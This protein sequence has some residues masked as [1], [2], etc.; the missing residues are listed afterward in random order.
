MVIVLCSH[1]EFDCHG[2]ENR[3]RRWFAVSYTVCCTQMNAVSL[4]LSLSPSLS[5]TL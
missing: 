2:I 5:C 1:D 4:F 3:I